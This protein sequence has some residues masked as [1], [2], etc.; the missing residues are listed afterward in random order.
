MR[1]KMISGIS[2]FD[3]KEQHNFGLQIHGKKGDMT[4]DKSTESKSTNKSLMTASVQLLTGK[5]FQGS[6]KR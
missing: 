2:V 4:R 5:Q 1:E 3:L 6:R